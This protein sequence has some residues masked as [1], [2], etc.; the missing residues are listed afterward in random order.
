METLQTEKEGEWKALPINEEITKTHSLVAP[1]YGDKILVYGGDY[2][3]QK[4][5]Y[6]LDED[7]L[8]LLNLSHDELIPGVTCLASFIVQEGKI[9]AVGWNKEKGSQ[10]WSLRVFEGKKWSLL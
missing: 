4:Y 3:A 7:G 6:L 10:K 1:Q 9:F 5:S 2:E 8:L